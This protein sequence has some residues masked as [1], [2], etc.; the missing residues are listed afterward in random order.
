MDIIPVIDLKAGQVVHARGGRRDE[1]RP[2]QTPLS[3]TSNPID[4]V[5]GLRTVFA[6]SRLYIADLDAIEHAGDHAATLTALQATWPALE[7]WVDN[8]VTNADDAAS[9]L[10]RRAGSL[11]IGSES[12][13]SPALLMSLRGHPRVV[14]SLDFRGDA[15]Q[16]PPEILADTNAWPQR[17]IVMTLARVGST[18][19]PDLAR[20]S[21]ISR[22]AAGRALYAAGGVRNAADLVNAAT[23]GAVG[24]LVA[25]SLHNGALTA[26][27]I[28]RLETSR[29]PPPAAGE[30]TG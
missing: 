10:A 5:A 2:I 17:I 18:A 28:V 4:V 21:D 24:A 22:R 27:D 19:G 6:F 12:Q 29:S 30:K 20:I 26:A 13:T 8:G 11:V 1:Y 14:L 15:F 25:T 16:G 23:S 7:L 3:P 9:F